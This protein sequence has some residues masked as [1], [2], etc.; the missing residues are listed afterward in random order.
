M[1]VS[2]YV[3]VY[4]DVSN[5]VCRYGCVVDESRSVQYVISVEVGVSKWVPKPICKSW[6][7]L[8]S[9]SKWRCRS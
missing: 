8:I 4:V 6:S 7:V 3:C 1:G 2:N 5:E 9:V